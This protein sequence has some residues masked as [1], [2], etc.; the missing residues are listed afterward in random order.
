M[1]F[2]VPTLDDVH[3]FLLAQYGYLNP[4]ADLSQGSWPWLWLRTMAAA[5]TGNHAQISAVEN[6]L[7]PDT[8]L[9]DML[10]RWATI[11]GRPRKGATGAIGSKVLRV[12]GTSTTVVASGQELK[13]PSGLTYQI[14]TGDVVGPGGYVDV[15]VAAIDVGAATML[16]AGTVLTFVSTPAGL[17]ESAVLQDDLE[18]GADQETDGAL[19]VRVV[20]RFSNP[21]LGGAANDYVTWAK[22]V[23]GVAAAYCYPIR[24]GLGSVDIVALHAGTGSDRVLTGP[25]VA[26]VQAY[27]DSVRPVGMKDARV[28]TVTPV[29][30]DVDFT[31][32]TDGAIQNQFDW[33]DT[34]VPTVAAWTAGTRTLQFSTARP[35]TMQAGDRV[36]IAHAG[37][38]GVQRVVES[39]VSTDSVV[40]EVATGVD[41]P[42]VGDSVY[43]G[44]PLVEPVRQAIIA[45]F[46]SLGAANPDANRYGAWEGNLRPTAISRAALSVAGTI[47]GTVVTP[48]TTVAAADPAYPLDGTIELLV[49]GRIL[50]RAQ[51]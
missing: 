22:S 26:T 13:S 39:L 42:S 1:A 5:V 43:A 46:D 27:I 36:S 18:S 19:S 32:V 23:T 50:V 30:T 47:D 8:A 21:P 7:M 12:S 2:P 20:D 14:T 3:G 31:I 16:T 44:G 35:A 9:G 37:G 25:E 29:S 49:P 34:V 24:A 40:L 15:D 33:D 28:L 4:S 38:N 45:L 11:V 51:H 10:D 41:D 6:D 17:S 48:A